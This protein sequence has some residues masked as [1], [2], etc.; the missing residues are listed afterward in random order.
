MLMKIPRGGQKKQTPPP[1]PFYIFND[2]F[3]FAFLSKI[4]F[5]SIVI[6]KTSSVILRAGHF[7]VRI[8]THL[9]FTVKKDCML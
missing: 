2:A 4:A 3:S 7:N 5:H 8:V 9:K 6:A 1:P